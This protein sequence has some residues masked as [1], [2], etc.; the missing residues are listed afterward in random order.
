MS[1]VTPLDVVSSQ[2]AD[3]YFGIVNRHANRKR[4]DGMVTGGRC[5]KSWRSGHMPDRV[6]LNKRQW[7]KVMEV[8]TWQQREHHI[9]LSKSKEYL[10]SW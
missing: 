9:Y 2:T 3:I 1:S 10:S 6:Q 5:N 7:M 4:C 8:D